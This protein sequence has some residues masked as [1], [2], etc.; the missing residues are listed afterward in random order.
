MARK[1]LI[2]LVLAVL[3]VAPHVAANNVNAGGQKGIVRAMSAETYGFTGINVGVA[4]KWDRDHTY[5]SGPN[6]TGRVVESSTGA[7]VDRDSPNIFSTATYLG[8]GLARLWDIS[9]AVPLYYDVTGWDKQRPGIGD[10]EIATKLAFPC[11][12]DDAFFKHAYYGKVTF[13]TGTTDRGYFPRHA[14]YLSRDRLDPGDNLVSSGSVIFFP[15]LL[16]TLDFGNVGKGFPLQ[17]HGNLGG[18]VTKIKNRSAV[19]GAIGIEY[20]PVRFLTF[21]AEASGESRVMHYTKEFSV[22]SFNNDPLLIT[23]GVRLRPIKG[24]YITLAGDFGLSSKEPKDRVTWDRGGYRYSTSPVPTYGA[25]V[26]IGWEGFIKEPDRDKDGVPDSKDKCLA[27]AEDRDTFE[28]D[29]GCPDPDND[30][31]GVLDAKDRC[32]D[33][34]A[35]TDGCPV[36]DKDGDGI[37]GDADKCPDQAEDKDGYEDADGCPEYDNDEDGIPDDKDGCPNNPEDMDGYEDAD[38]C[39][40]SDND[41][42]GIPD[43]SDQCPNHRGLPENNGCPKT[44]EIKRGQLVLR[45]VNFESGKAVLTRTSYAILDGV[46]ESLREWSEVTLEIQG[47]TDSQGSAEFN[48]RLSQRRAQAVADYLTGKGISRSRIEAKGYGEDLPIAD[49]STAEGR[50]QNRRVELKRTD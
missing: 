21:F 43:E 8:F 48:Q 35:T 6:G 1:A 24:T 2:A 45:G 32:P 33:A 5:V 29:D 50:A 10:L 26:A 12:T 34:P 7:P 42:D 49:N 22:T 4:G 27:Q 36:V 11:Q 30:N 18:A 38:G 25:H 17:I 16:W 13:P 41:G 46:Y 28:D 15:A 23:P 14:Y 39:R 9:A 31:D 44:E 3:A 37:T 40:D 47:H 20:T 19:L